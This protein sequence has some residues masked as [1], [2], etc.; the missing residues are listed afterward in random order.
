M[1]FFKRF[2]KYFFKILLIPL[3]LS[4]ILFLI[5]Q[6][7]IAA[8]IFLG[9]SVSGLMLA[10]W[11]Y[12][13]EQAQKEGESRVKTGTVTRVLIVVVAC[14]IWYRFQDHINI[15]GF[16]GGLSMT[17]I[18]MMYRVFKEMPKKKR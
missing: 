10:N 11:L 13:L 4:L 3:L 18:L 16:I 12:H 2:Y 7:P 5:T 1:P 15:F 9:T 6:S 8:G 17:Y 14:L